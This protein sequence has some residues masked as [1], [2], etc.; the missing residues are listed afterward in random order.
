[1][2]VAAAIRGRR[3]VRDYT[4]RPV[5]DDVL[6]R[7]LRLALAAPTGSGAQAWDL[8][9]VRDPDLGRRVAE[10]VIDGGARYFAINRP[11]AEGADDEAHAAWAR[12]N[13]ERLLATYRH[14]PVWVLGCVTPRREYPPEMAQTGPLDDVMSVAFA[15]ENLMLAARAVGLGTCPTTA[16][17]QLEEQRLR[18]ALEIPDDVRPVV[19]TPVGYPTRFPEGRPPALRNGRPWRTFVHDDAYGHGRGEAA[20]PAA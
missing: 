11:R 2:D 14:V 8:V 3:A 20:D 15:M 18:A 1:M 9:V 5:P 17:W 6:D 16:F 19:L 4:D 10:I 7:L 12:G 13:A